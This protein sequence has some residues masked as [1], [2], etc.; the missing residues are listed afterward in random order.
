MNA[1]AAMLWRLART[2]QQGQGK[3]PVS[4]RIVGVIHSHKRNGLKDLANAPRPRLQ[5]EILAGPDIAIRFL[6]LGRWFILPYHASK[7]RMPLTALSRWRRPHGL[8]ESYRSAGLL[9]A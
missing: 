3:E 2:C 6:T 8:I 4:C 5:P 7:Y 1:R 9:P